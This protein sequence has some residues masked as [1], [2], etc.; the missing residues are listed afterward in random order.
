METVK[1]CIVMLVI[2]A[3]FA[4]MPELAAMND[5]KLV[6]WEEERTQAAV[7]ASA[8]QFIDKIM[9][10]DANVLLRAKTT[11]ERK[12]LLDRWVAQYGLDAQNSIGE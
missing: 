2:A 4:P 3:G 10:R 11:E 7:A 12:Q 8:R 1:K 9:I 5:D 6:R